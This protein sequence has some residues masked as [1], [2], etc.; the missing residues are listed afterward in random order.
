MPVAAVELFF[1]DLV[2]CGIKRALFCSWVPSV[3]LTLSIY[4]FLDL[5]TPNL[6]H[7][8]FPSN[9]LRGKVVAESVMSQQN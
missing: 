2:S 6:L 5:F 8:V 9:V 3:L 1:T 4:S 7:R